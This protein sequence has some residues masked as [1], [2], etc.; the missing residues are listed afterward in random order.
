MSSTVLN[1]EAR[2]TIGEL[3]DAQ[4]QRAV[5]ALAVDEAL[6]GA[7]R[8]AVD[9]ELGRP[10]SAAV[11]EA[12]RTIV[13][14]IAAVHAQHAAESAGERYGAADAAALLRLE[15]DLRRALAAPQA[16]RDRRVRS[17]LAAERGRLERRGDDRVPRAANLR[18]RGL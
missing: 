16:Q 2:A 3:V 14:A 12:T 11:E 5:D 17:L 1:D 4:V 8:E 7:V 9:V 13:E 18:V 6:A 10:P 15:A